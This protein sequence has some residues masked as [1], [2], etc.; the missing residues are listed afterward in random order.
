MSART[1]WGAGCGCLVLLVIFIAF[2][3]ALIGGSSEEDE[4]VSSTET[5]ETTEETKTEEATE[6]TYEESFEEKEERK[7]PTDPDERLRYN[8]QEDLTRQ[9]PDD[10]PVEDVP[11]SIEADQNG[12]RH[13]SASYTTL[14]STWIETEMRGAYETVYGDERTREV[15]CS[16]SLYAYGTLTDRYGQ[17]SLVHL[18]TTHMNR[19]VADRVNWDQPYMAR[20]EELWT[21]DYVHPT[22]QAEIEQENAEQVLDCMQQGGIFDFDWLECP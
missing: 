1:Q 22:A 10:R 20:L 3:G 19:D 6:R 15:T 17:E 16:L 18:Y 7:K 21:T 5:E 13:V 4:Q 11:V 12:C 14:G 9:S 8:L 2:L